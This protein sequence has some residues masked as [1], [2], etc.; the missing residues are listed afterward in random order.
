MLFEIYK[1]NPNAKKVLVIDAR[2]QIAAYGN[3][4]KGV[5]DD[6]QDGVE[7]QGFTSL[8]P[9][10]MGQQTPLNPKP[11]LSKFTSNCRVTRLQSIVKLSCLWRPDEHRTRSPDRQAIGSRAG[12]V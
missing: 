6:P 5:T 11:D 9:L 3:K 1:T 10:E 8:L 12:Q 7:I 4:A 2:S